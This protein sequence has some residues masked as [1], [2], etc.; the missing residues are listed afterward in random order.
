MSFSW[1]PC[2]SKS[3]SCPAKKQ[4][5]HWLSD[6][7][8]KIILLAK[9][10]KRIE[11][12]NVEHKKDLEAMHAEHEEEKRKMRDVLIRRLRKVRDVMSSTND[13]DEDSAE[14]GGGGGGSASGLLPG[15]GGG[16]GGKKKSEGDD[17]AFIM[18]SSAPTAKSNEKMARAVTLYEREA[19][20]VSE[21]IS[22]MSTE[23]QQ[24]TAMLAEQRK[25]NEKLVLRNASHI[26]TRSVLSDQVREVTDR[27][28]HADKRQQEDILSRKQ[29]ITDTANSQ[30]EI[31]FHLQG[32]LDFS[33]EEYETA[34]LKLRALQKEMHHKG[35]AVAEANKFFTETAMMLNTPVSKKNEIPPLS[36]A[37]LTTDTSDFSSKSGIKKDT[38]HEA[39]PALMLKTPTEIASFFSAA[40][41]SY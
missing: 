38:P 1:R 32:E 39:I 4:A 41:C 9:L 26:K 37:G 17:T 34:K 6:R 7:D 28:T 21:S 13:D 35:S 36:K 24:S 8:K 23:L 18:S 29:T 25:L 22:E 20:T 15:G 31:L 12:K 33:L 3:S 14:T 40:L 2:G 10:E 19:C 16:P 11:E 30:S 27:Y 5:T